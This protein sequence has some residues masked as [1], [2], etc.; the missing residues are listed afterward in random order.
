MQAECIAHTKGRCLGRG[1]RTCGWPHVTAAASIQCTYPYF[2]NQNHRQCP[3]LLCPYAHSPG[4]RNPVRSADAWSA[5][6]SDE[7]WAEWEATRA[8]R[9]GEPNDF[10][11]ESP[12]AALDDIIGYDGHG[13]PGGS[14]GSRST[15]ALEDAATAGISTASAMSSAS[16]SHTAAETTPGSFVTDNAA[17]LANLQRMLPHLFTNPN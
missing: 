14:A 12:L 3:H 17:R 2:W 16:G 10:D 8:T 4:V 11:T 15:A 13:G 7:K 1:D 6:W 9:T 5:P